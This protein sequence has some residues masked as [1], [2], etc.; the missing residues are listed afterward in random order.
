MVDLISKDITTFEGILGDERPDYPRRAII[1]GGSDPAKFAP[2]I[3]AS[4]HSDEFW[5]NFNFADFIVDQEIPDFTDGK[6]KS[7]SAM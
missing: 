1:V 4:M 5:L 2:N 3:N 7:R 6:L